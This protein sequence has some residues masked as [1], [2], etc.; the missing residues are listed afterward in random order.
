MDNHDFDESG[1][2][3][4]LFQCIDRAL[5]VLGDTAKIALYY[6]VASESGLKSDELKSRPFTVI[7]YLQ[8][9]LGDVGYSF[10]EKPIIHEIKSTF[11]LELRDGLTIFEAIN[12]A[13]EKFFM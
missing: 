11:K 6:R 3:G 5:S 8:T 12:V 7:R 9:I 2:D 13:H 4:T 1:I 10:V